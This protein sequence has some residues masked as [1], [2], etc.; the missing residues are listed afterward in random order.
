MAKNVQGFAQRWSSERIEVPC[1][2]GCCWPA[3]FHFC[4]SRVPAQAAGRNSIYDRVQY[5]CANHIGPALWA[6]S[7]QRPYSPSACYSDMPRI[8]GSLTDIRR[9]AGHFGGFSVPLRRAA[10]KFSRWLIVLTAKTFGWPPRSVG[11]HR[12]ACIRTYL[13]RRPLPRL[14]L[15]ASHAGA[16]GARSR[17]ISDRMSANICRD[18]ATSASW[19][20]T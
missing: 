19:K 20:V 11:I 2:S 7:V 5:W 4:P 6:S 15:L 14:P 8:G 9:I 16:G 1:P 12:S 17:E 18:T 10:R 13:A 3:V